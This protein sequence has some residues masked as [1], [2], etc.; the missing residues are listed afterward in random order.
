MPDAFRE[1]DGWGEP[2]APLKTSGTATLAL[3]AGVLSFFCLFGVGGVLAIALGWIAHS[4]IE[5]SDGRL[6]G[7]GLAST[8][9]G[10]GIANLVVSVVGIG[11][12]VA[13]AVRPDPPRALL[14]PPPPP[15]LPAPVLPR[16]ALPPP[17]APAPHAEVADSDPALPALPS[18]VGK[19]V[20]VEAAAGADA[21]EQQLLV[22]LQASAKA[23]EQVVLW[24]VTPDCEPCAA[25]GRAL[26]DARMQRALAKV[27]LVRADA[28]SFPGELQRLG[29][30]I[31][32]VPGFTLLDPHA[33]ALDHIHGGEWDAD[34][35]ANIAPILDRF[36]R[37]SLAPRRHPWSRPL[38]D[39]ET[40]L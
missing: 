28:A 23:G 8:G 20:I 26:P 12:L 9:I 35:P 10:L 5:R 11:V 4:E 1:P 7:K 40:P 13:L 25:V 30:P 29:V 24:T 19:I 3:A 21:L 33:H 34:I 17:A 14:A 15:A 37:H 36:L 16:P 6:A 31:E 39:G 2:L 27:R 32:S 18:R 38:R 22:Q